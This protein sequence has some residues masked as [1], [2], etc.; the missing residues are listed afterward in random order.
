LLVTTY[1]GASADNHTYWPEIYT[2]FPIVAGMPEQ[3]DSNNPL[4]AASSFDPQLFL[5]IDD[6]V[7]VLLNQKFFDHQYTPVEVAQWLEDFASAAASNLA[8]AKSRVSNP[9]SPAFRRLAADVAIQS[10]LGFFFSYKFRAGVLWSIYQKT[11][12]AEAKTAALAQYAKA[13]QAWT[14]LSAAATPVYQSDITYGLTPQM[15][16]HWSDRLPGIDADIAA[17]KKGGVVGTPTHP[18]A[19][20]TAILAARPRPTRPVAGCRHDAPATF[21][22]GQPLPL[23]LKSDA[24]S[25]KLFYRRVNQA[26]QWQVLAME[27]HDGRFHGIIPAG[28]TQTKF[29]LQYNFGV[30]HGERGAVPFPGLDSTL[31]NQPYFVVRL[32][33]QA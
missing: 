21:V 7:D 12:D 4:G 13:R 18:G 25:V 22:A 30:D 9:S 29:P 24:K 5:G 14:D 27:K 2:N 23:A 33:K 1:H 11:G 16:G 6:Y 28:Y 10:G 15:R 3:H 19:A 17:M 32:K 26:E 20:A 31:A 8:T